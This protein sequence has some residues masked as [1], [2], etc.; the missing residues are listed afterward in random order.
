MTAAL[1][2]IDSPFAEPDFIKWA[3]WLNDP[4]VVRFSE[5]RHTVHTPDTCRAYAASFQ[6]TPHWLWVLMHYEAGHI[7]NLTAHIDPHN[8][9]A[10]LAILI[11]EKEFWRGGYGFR[12]WRAAIH[13][14]TLIG[15]VRKF[16]AGTLATHTAMKTIME[17]NFM[18]P[19]GVRAKHRW[20][21]G[22]EVDVLYFARWAE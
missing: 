16:T 6:G 10:E 3:S 11:G 12:A 14:L 22:Q 4:E 1:L 13:T 9:T 5:Q 18:V 2:R 8:R 7:G 20:W 17:R 15:S 19:D 21:E